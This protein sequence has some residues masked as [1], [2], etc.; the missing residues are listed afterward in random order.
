MDARAAEAR[1]YDLNPCFPADE[2]FYLDRLP[3]APA[4][5]LAL[6][7]AAVTW[8]A[9]A[10]TAHDGY[11]LDRAARTI[12]VRRVSPRQARRYEAPA[13]KATTEIDAVREEAVLSSETSPSPVSPPVEL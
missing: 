7:G 1:Y 9:V 3:P 11:L 2:S 12:H 13:M 6:I 8:G 4:P 10:R 5:L